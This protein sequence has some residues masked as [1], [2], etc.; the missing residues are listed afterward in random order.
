M[1]N[2]INSYKNIFQLIGDI[3][4]Y[5]SNEAQLKLQL[6]PIDTDWESIVKIASSHLV[7]TTLYC[8]LKQKKLLDFLPEDLLIYIKELTLINR[9]RNLELLKEIQEISTVLNTHEIN[10]VF[11]KGCALLAGNYFK[12]FGERLIGDIDILVQPDQL[13]KASQLLA[14][15]GYTKSISFNYEVKNYRHLPRQVSDDKFGAVELHRHILNKKYSHLIDTKVVLSNKTIINGVSIPSVDD[16]I[17]III[18]AHQIN[19][20]GNYYNTLHYKYA[21]DC[22]TLQLDS[23]KRLLEKLSIKKI[24]LNFLTLMNVQFPEIEIYK[25]S[26]PIKIKRALFILKL[27]HKNFRIISYKIKKSLQS[28]THRL[29]LM[30]YNKS[31]R[32]YILKNKI[33]KNS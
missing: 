2:S 12:D 29:G 24:T 20:K 17:R 26:L 32:S 10:Y 7:L 15:K 33:L 21:C 23:N 30:I 18:L 22:L 8:R 6:H 27:N 25:T 3:L 9:N 16:L 13:E 19:D 14:L 5:Q 31:Y 28:I 4:S 11:L 1:T